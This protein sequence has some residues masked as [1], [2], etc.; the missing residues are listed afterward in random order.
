M[1]NPSFSPKRHGT[2]CLPPFGGPVCDRFS[3]LP[4]RAFGAV[5]RKKLVGSCGVK[6]A[7]LQAVS[8]CVAV[9]FCGTRSGMGAAL[10]FANRRN[11]GRVLSRDAA[12]QGI[13]TFFYLS[14][15]E[16]NSMIL[17]SR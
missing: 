15:V 11:L 2:L 8:R 3:A 5:T 12:R 16:L 14:C 10:Y 1:L 13:S 4:F 17:I 9:T 7:R 6:T